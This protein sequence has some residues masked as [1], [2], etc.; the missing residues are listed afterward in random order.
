MLR[1]SERLLVIER[2][3]E[4]N[5][6][7]EWSRMHDLTIKPSSVLSSSRGSSEK[8]PTARKVERRSIDA[9]GSWIVGGRVNRIRKRKLN[10]IKWVADGHERHGISIFHSP[11]FFFSPPCLVRASVIRVPS[12]TPFIHFILCQIFSSGLFSSSLF[13]Q[14]PTVVSTLIFSPWSMAIKHRHWPSLSH[15]FLSSL[16]H[17]VHFYYVVNICQSHTLTWCFILVSSTKF[18]FVIN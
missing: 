7:R 8:A 6:H 13:S 10:A 15:L 2:E 11:C 17:P 1:Y 4:Y 12:G 14:Y 16:T 9:A 18:L 3:N 5:D